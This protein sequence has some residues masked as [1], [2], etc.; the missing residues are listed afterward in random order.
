MSALLHR[1]HGLRPAL[2]AYC[3][4]E[5]IHKM[6]RRLFAVSLL[7][8]SVVVA[9]AAEPS[10]GMPAGAR[11]LEAET[12]HQHRL[13]HDQCLDLITLQAPVARDARFVTGVLDAIV[14]LE[15]IGDYAYETVTLIS[16]MNRRPASQISSQMSELSAKIRACLTTAVESWR[17]VVSSWLS[18]ESLSPGAGGDAASERISA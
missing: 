1:R 13:I 12:D 8:L 3:A 2:E 11:E 7:M 5:R 9:H 6:M 16:S 15:L 17:S 4:P 10:S 14:D 18:A